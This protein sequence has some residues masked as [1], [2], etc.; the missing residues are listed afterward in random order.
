MWRLMVKNIAWGSSEKS[1]LKDGAA[2][3]RVDGLYF[4]LVFLSSAVVIGIVV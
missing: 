3:V 2:D 1:L 4:V